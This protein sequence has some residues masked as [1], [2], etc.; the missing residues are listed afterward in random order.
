MNGPIAAGQ[1]LR[2]RA[3]GTH[4]LGLRADNQSDEEEEKKEEEVEEEKKENGEEEIDF[5]QNR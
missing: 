4:N 5:H 2:A 3:Q 1:A